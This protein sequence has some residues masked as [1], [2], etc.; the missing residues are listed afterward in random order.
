MELSEFALKLSDHLVGAS[1][2]LPVPYSTAC[3]EQGNAVLAH[4]KAVDVR[5]WRKEVPTSVRAGEL[6]AAV[7]PAIRTLMSV[8]NGVECRLAAHHFG[9]AVRNFLPEVQDASS[10]A[11][12]VGVAA[13]EADTPKDEGPFAQWVSGKFTVLLEATATLVQTLSKEVQ[14]P[15]AQGAPTASAPLR[16]VQS[17]AAPAASAAASFGNPPARGAST[18]APAQDLFSEI[19]GVCR[20]TPRSQFCCSYN[21][22]AHGFELGPAANPGTGAPRCQGIG[23]GKEAQCV[24]KGL[25]EHKLLTAADVAPQFRAELASRLKPEYK[26]AHANPQG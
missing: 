7:Y 12:S 18:R 11:L 14:A 25:T 26:M 5:M 1:F 9:Q 16:Q 22:R 24:I 3:A 15:R 20:H 10:V 21:L 4:L 23:H 19:L 17:R 2:V 13:L 8:A 6:S